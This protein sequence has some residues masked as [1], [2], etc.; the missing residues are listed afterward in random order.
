MRCSSAASRSS[1]RR[2]ISVWANGSYARSASAG[3]AP[4]RQ[5]LAQ[6]LGAARSGSAVARFADAA[7]RSGR[8][9][10][11]TDRRAGVAGRPGDEPALAQ[12]LAQPARRRPGCSS[13]PS[14]AALSPE[15]VDQ[16]V[17]GDDLVRVQQQQREQRALL[18]ARRARASDRAR[19]PPGGQGAGIPSESPAGSLRP[20][21]RIERERGG[22]LAER[23]LSAR[24]C[25][26]SSGVAVRFLRWVT[27]SITESET[28]TRPRTVPA[29]MPASPQL[30]PDESSITS[31]AGLLTNLVSVA[32][33]DRWSTYPVSAAER[34]GKVWM[35]SGLR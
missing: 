4:E 17:G 11:R 13:P 32:S 18:D 26:P 25:R 20:Y 10:A 33:G 14:A 27:L 12:L 19:R 1:S 23:R 35:R 16:A 31:G 2:A 6:L 22:A 34:P 7:A 29:P 3:A 30:K 21:H 9:R 15:L 5:R 28:S 8:G 24:R